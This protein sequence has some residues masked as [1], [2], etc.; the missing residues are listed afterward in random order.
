MQH[1]NGLKIGWHREHTVRLSLD[2]F[3]QTFIILTIVK[4]KKFGRTRNVSKSSDKR[5]LSEGQSSV[6]DELQKRVVEGIKWNTEDTIEVGSSIQHSNPNK[7]YSGFHSFPKPAIIPEWDSPAQQLELSNKANLANLTTTSTGNGDEGSLSLDLPVPSPLNFIIVTGLSTMAAMLHNGRILNIPCDRGPPVPSIFLSLTHS[8]HLYP[9][10]LA[11][12]FLQ[13]TVPHFPYVDLLPFPS[14]RD[15]LLKA[16][17]IVNALEMW[18]DLSNGGVKVWGR[19]SWDER[20]WEVG[21]GFARKW[22]FLMD[23][24]ILRVTNFWRRLRD[25]V[26]LEIGAL[27][28]PTQGNVWEL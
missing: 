5:D 1:A 3:L 6:V 21:E 15:N 19:Q 16:G 10:A 4:G 14:L 20:N 27:K 13:S 26:D 23:E 8:T 22:W 7:T 25:E 28:N 2:P 17:E 18:S 11:P 9:A 12:T 24:S